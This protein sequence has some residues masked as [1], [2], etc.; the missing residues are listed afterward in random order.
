MFDSWFN[1]MSNSLLEP[2]YLFIEYVVRNNNNVS[3]HILHTLYNI[4]SAAS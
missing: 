3:I 1:I 2:Y 4:Y